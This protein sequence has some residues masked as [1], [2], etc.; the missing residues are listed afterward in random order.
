MDGAYSFENRWL[1]CYLYMI[2][3]IVPNGPMYCF[4]SSVLMMHLFVTSWSE[5]FAHRFDTDNRSIDNNN[6]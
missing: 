5:N 2:N 1:K 4:M 6:R 3:A